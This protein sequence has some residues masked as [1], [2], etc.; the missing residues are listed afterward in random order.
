M[1]LG[2]VGI[3]IEGDRSVASAVQQILAEFAELIVGRMGLP[4]LEHNVCM[5]T[6]GVKG[7]QEKISAMAGKLGRLKGVKVKSAVSDIN[8]E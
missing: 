7:E 2:F 8:I 4:N 5:I 1:K 3:I 6:V